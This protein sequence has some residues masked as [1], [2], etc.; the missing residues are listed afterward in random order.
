MIDDLL[1]RLYKVRHY[2][3]G[4]Y[5]ACC[6]AHEDKTPSLSIKAGDDGRILVHCFAECPVEEVLAAVGLTFDALYP[7]KLEGHTQPRMRVDP[8]A[9]LDAVAHELTVCAVYV[10]DVRKGDTP[11]EADHAR[12][13]T[14]I[15]R[16]EA[17]RSLCAR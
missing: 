15:G 7:E 10:A 14:A 6:P 3:N 2:G 11:S 8:R 12:F 9:A 13:L 17:A 16:I 1:Q 5:L 4:Q